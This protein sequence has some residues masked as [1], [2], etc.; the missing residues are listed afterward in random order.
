M[1]Y[2]TSRNVMTQRLHQGKTAVSSLAETVDKQDVRR[3]ALGPVRPD[4]PLGVKST[5]KSKN[6]DYDLENSDEGTVAQRVMNALEG[7]C[8]SKRNT[9]S[10]SSKV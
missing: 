2:A 4:I 8:P 5:R 9:N 3:S 6:K 10:N 7:S 1:I